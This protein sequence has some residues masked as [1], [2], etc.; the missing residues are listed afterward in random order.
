M[1]MA[2]CLRGAVCQSGARA[3][4]PPYTLAVMRVMSMG[5]ASGEI[6]SSSTRD[7]PSAVA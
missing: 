1:L 3:P 5:F 6:V 2:N 7:P 4:E